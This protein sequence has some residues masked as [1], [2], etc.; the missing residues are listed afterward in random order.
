LEALKYAGALDYV[1]EDNMAQIQKV[2]SSVVKVL[3]RYRVQ[4]RRRLN[5][6]NLREAFD[7]AL[8]KDKMA[9][10][11]FATGCFVGCVL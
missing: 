2:K 10:F 4:V 7:T 1:P 5:P 6:E 9:T 3:D 8:N 11:G